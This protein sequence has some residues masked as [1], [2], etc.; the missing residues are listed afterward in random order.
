MTGV[1]EGPPHDASSPGLAEKR[2]RFSAKSDRGYWITLYGVSIVFALICVGFLLSVISESA[3]AW[4]KYGT[5]ILTGTVWNQATNQFG[6]LPLIA[7]TVETTVIALFLAV[8]I[9]IGTALAIVHLL[10]TRLRTVTSSV[11]ELLAAIPSVVYGFWGLLVIG[12]WFAHTVL[13]WFVHLFHGKFPFQDP[14]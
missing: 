3:P 5:S 9:G 2:F 12:P 13:P 10:P 4:E 11:V 14:P 8:P 7:G 1:T 6:A